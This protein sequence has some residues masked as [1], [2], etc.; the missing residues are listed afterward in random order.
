MAD[1]NFYLVRPKS[2]TL[3]LTQLLA[4]YLYSNKKL[5][6]RSIGTFTLHSAAIMEA[7][8][9]RSSKAEIQGTINFENNAAAKTE[10]DLIEYISSHT[11]KQKALAAADLESYL[12][13][14][15]QFLNIGKPFL[16]EG[17]GTL[18]KTKESQYTF[19]QGNLFTERVQDRNMHR[20]A[21]VNEEAMPDFKSVFLK[22]PKTINWRKPLIAL[23][24]LI[25][26][27]LVVGGGYLVYKRTSRE[28]NVS[29]NEM[30]LINSEDT[31]GQATQNSIQDSIPSTPDSTQINAQVK[32]QASAPTS[33]NYKIVVDQ[34]KAQRAF[35][36][37]AQLKD[38]GWPIHMETKDSVRY[39]LFVLMPVSTTDTTRAIDSLTA[40]NGRKVYIEHQNK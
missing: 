2:N 6:L 9:S 29:E 7:D 30:Q 23:F 20:E 1:K 8:N 16:F 12:E 39:K 33:N 27:G 34:F 15:Q 38:N 18:S 3:K 37:Y 21:A 26:L 17:I 22:A 4:E 25:G 10:P 31:T 13:L 11:G 19:T 36:R 24:I 28:N 5:E 40:L 14:A 35:R 32:Q